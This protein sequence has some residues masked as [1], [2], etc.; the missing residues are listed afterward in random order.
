VKNDPQ[1]PDSAR[2]SGI[3]VS[4]GIVIGTALVVGRQAGPAPDVALAPEEVDAEI[5]RF[6]DAIRMSYEQLEDL[7]RRVEDILGPRDAAIF[8][9]HMM[10]VADQMLLDEV[11]ERV[12]SE[13]KTSE[14]VFQEVLDRYTSALEG[15]DD[16]YIRDRLADIRDVANRVIKNLRGEE[17][18]DL[19]SLSKPCIVVAPDLSPSDTAGMDRVNVIGFATELGSRTSHTAIMACSLGIPAAVG[20]ARV[21]ESVSTGDLLILDGYKGLVIVDPDEETLTR[22]KQRIHDQ[23]QWFKN[24]ARELALPAETIDGFRVRLAANVERPDEVDFVK[25][26]HGVGIGLFRTE[27]LFVN[28]TS[29]PT[30]EQQF[31][32][33]RKTAEAILPRAVI[34]RTLDIGGD[35][36]LSHLELPIEM[37]PFLGIRAIRFCLAQP[38][39]FMSQLRAILRASAHGKVRIMFPMI[40]TLDELIEA[41]SYLERA[42]DELSAEGVPFNPHLDVGIMVEVPGA[43]LTADQLAKH[44]DFFSIGT[45][46][47]VQYTLAADRSNPDT[48]YL[49]QPCHPSIISLIH[50]VAQAASA[51]NIWVSVCGEMAADPLMV[52]LILGLGIHELSMSPVGLAVVKRL[53]RRIRMHEAEALVQEALTCGKTAEV[54]ELCRQFV[55]RVDPEIYAD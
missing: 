17:T 48:S 29:L 31:A 40:A 51:N 5:A 47:L 41:L 45:N 55:V 22:Y 36:F 8:D 15:L 13:C 4:A 16:S 21:T 2:C 34:F 24:L 42:K 14:F 50:N 30:E 25:K 33:Y 7:K 44:V 53:I 32:A 26:N 43:A 18:A 27:Y 37:N 23:G 39:I 19:A 54:V 28:E 11:T 1:Q 10:L 6:N 49:Y 52:P 38:A 9:A 12:R 3:G 20:V 46:D 35:K